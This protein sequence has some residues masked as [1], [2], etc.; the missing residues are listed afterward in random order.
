MMKHAVLVGGIVL[1][2]NIFSSREAS[3][4]TLKTHG[5]AYEPSDRIPSDFRE[6]SR[7][8]FFG[9]FHTAGV[10][11]DLSDRDP[12]LVPARVAC[13]LNVNGEWTE[14]HD[15]VQTGHSRNYVTSLFW[16][17]PASRYQ[18][19][20]RLQFPDEK[21]NEVWFG[22]GT[23]RPEPVSHLSTTVLHVSKTGSDS[24]PGT[25]TRPLKSIR[26]AL[27]MAGPGD[28]VK[29]H[30]G[31][32]YESSLEF[33]NSGRPDAPVTLCS[34]D[35]ETV[36][37][38]GTNETLTSPKTWK[39]THPGI[40][41]HSLAGKTHHAC[42][43][44]DITG[45]T[46]RLFPVNAPRD[47]LSRTLKSRSDSQDR[48]SFSDLGIEGAFYADG[49][50]VHLEIPDSLDRFQVQLSGAGRAIQLRRRSHI[51]IAGLEF[52]HF[53]LGLNSTAIFVSD[54]SDITIA[55]CVFRYNNS[56]IYLKGQSDRVTIQDCSFVDDLLNWPFDLMKQEGGVSGSFEG[57]AV[58]V[59]ASFSGRGLVFRRNRISGLFDGAHLTPYRKNDARTNEIDFCENVIDGCVDD[60]L[61]ADGFSRNVRIFD[62]TMRR[63]LSGV[64]VAQA[65]DGPTFVIYNIISECGSVPAAARGEHYGY[66]FKT[67]G[68]HGA[69]EG[70]GPMFFYHNTAF[71][72]DPQ[73]RAI[74]IK[75]ARWKLL[76]LRNN[77]WCG[78]AAGLELWP[79]E[80]SPMDWDYDTLY[81]SQKSAPLLI[82]A[83]RRKFG[84]PGDITREFGWQMHGLYADPEFLNQ[85]TGD[86]D[87]QEDSP[88]ID[89]GVPLP[90]IN[91][92]RSEGRAPDSGARERR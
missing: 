21:H 84:T 52:R 73:S 14:M 83:Y 15:L 66:P 77:I 39:E 7:V 13:D 25:E 23:T 85:S 72:S 28:T 1:F 67:N 50:T 42:L 36:I 18:V 43:K 33:R 53:G 65:L 40:L 64:S 82:H 8:E 26:Q 68:D 55:D 91:S 61:E 24:D 35:G 2:L 79:R 37:L 22:Q 58:N 45:R 88:C 47:L 78:Q 29:V 60:F 38:D 62:N 51:R 5:Q 16:L 56:F 19:R 30:E 92:L 74:L 63:S 76:R 34:A 49:E 71:T 10:I 59:D 46:I 17:Q 80:P 57:G 12:S 11:A 86:F 90:G 4:S 70:S 44:D 27:V 6:S 48:M 75:Q 89:A 20:I 87:L 54:S 69:D 9:N 3:S 41:S 31:V 81:V 32:Y